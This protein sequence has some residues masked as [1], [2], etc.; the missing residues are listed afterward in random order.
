MTSSVCLRS[1]RS[2]FRIPPGAPHLFFG[3]SDIL[4]VRFNRTTE[5]PLAEAAFSDNSDTQLTSGGLRGQAVSVLP[6]SAP[7]SGTKASQAEVSPC[8]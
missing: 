8:R 5:R 2:G 6:C 1:K 4:I 7:E 3:F